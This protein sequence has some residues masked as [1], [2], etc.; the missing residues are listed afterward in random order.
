MYRNSEGYNDPTAGQALQKVK[1]EEKTAYGF[2][3][4]IRAAAGLMAEG[5]GYDLKGQICLKDKNTGRIYR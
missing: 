3:R 4:M 5:A 2:L 1:A